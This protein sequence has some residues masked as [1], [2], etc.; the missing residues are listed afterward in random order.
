MSNVKDANI[1]KIAVVLAD[2]VPQLT[3]FNQKQPLASIIQEL[4]NFW[5]LSDAEQYALQFSDSNN[6]NYITE[7]NRNE[8]KNGSV[9][10]LSFSPSKTASDILQVLQSGSNEE[11]VEAL[12]KL[13]DLSTDITFALEW[14]NKRGLSFI[15]E[16]IGG[17]KYKGAMLGLLLKSFV[18]LMDHGNVSWDILEDP[19]ISTVAGHVNSNPSH[20]D[21]MTIQASLSILENIVIN[22]SAKYNQV[23]SEVNFQNLEAHL[24]TENPVIQQNTLALVNSFMAKADSAKRKSLAAKLCTRQVKNAIIT[25]IIQ[26]SVT[27]GAEMAHQLYVYQS[28]LLDLLEPR[29]NTKMDSQDQDAHEKI[30]ELRKIAFDTEGS[31]GNDSIARRQLGVFAKDY[32]KLGFKSDINPAL[33]FTETPPGMLALDCMVYFARNQTENYTKM[34]SGTSP[35]NPDS[36]HCDPTADISDLVK[37]ERYFW[38]LPTMYP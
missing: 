26:K 37:Q 33:D 34:P 1:V 3:P 4:C 25:H 38:Y 24:A 9:L 29:M 23:V 11:K 19:F 2:Q 31:F 36:S 21:S 35:S 32:K 30:K 28:Y 18:E 14:I 12:T 10:R 27:V 16:L 22:S 17:N 20:Q 15:I 5:N 7:K 8:V 13:T 6:T